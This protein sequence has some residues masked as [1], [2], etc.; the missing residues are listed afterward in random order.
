MMG[1]LREHGHEALMVARGHTRT[2]EILRSRL[3]AL[4]LATLMIDAVASFLIL[5]FERNASGTQ[6]TN[7][8]DAIFWTSSQLLTVSSSM[9][10]PISTWGRVVD[11]VLEFWAITVVAILA[12]SFGAFFHRRGHEMDPPA[13]ASAE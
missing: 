11:I 2:H 3:V 13:A 6:I 12:G 9:S 4:F 5:M 8:G 10:N 1:P 7:I